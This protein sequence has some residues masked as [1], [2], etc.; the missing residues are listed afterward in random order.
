MVNLS[1]GKAAQA[2]MKNDSSST[3][4][5]GGTI[6]TDRFVLTAG[7]CCFGSHPVEMNIYTGS[8]NFYEGELYE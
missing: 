6:I 8:N 7:R 1:V 4:H 2:A 3:T 5:C